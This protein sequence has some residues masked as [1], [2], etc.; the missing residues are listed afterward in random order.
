MAAPIW[1]ASP[2]EVHSAL[3]SNGPGPGSLVA[4]ATA[5][6][7][8]S[9]EYAST[10]AEL[11]GLLGAVPGWAWQGPS[12]EWYVAAH[13]PYVAWLTQASADAA[14]AAAQHEAAAAAYTTA[15]AAMPTLAELAANHVIHTVLVATNFFGINTIPITLNEA[16]YVRM[17]LQAAAVM[18]LYQAAS[19]AALASAPRT[20]P[21][22][23]VMNPGGGAASTVGA[24]NPWQWLLALLQQLWNAYTGFY[25]WMLQLIWQF[26]QD[27]IGNSIKIIIAFLTNPIQALITYGPL[28]FALGYQIFF[29]LVG[30]PTWGMI[31]SSPFLLPAGLGLGLAAIAFLPIVLAP[32]VIPPASTPLAAA[33]VAAGSVWPAVS[34]AVTGAG[35]AWGCDARGGRGR[36]PA[37]SVPAEP[38]AS[39]R[40]CLATAGLAGAVPP[41]ASAPVAMAETR[42]W[43]ATA[44]TVGQ[45]PVGLL[46]V[47]VARAGCYSAKMG[48]PG[49]E[50]PNPGQPP[51]GNLHINWPGRQQTA[52]IYEIGSRSVGGA[53]KSGCK[54]WLGSVGWRRA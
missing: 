31:L 16:D 1:M 51:M 25:G 14:G 34:M 11:S 18:G 12:A 13:L 48:C 26:L 40:F 19:G 20:V 46:A 53:G 24:V 3:L 17:W 27:P 21:A 9:A 6:S 42:C 7:Q 28:L 36:A 29:N 54:S 22:P 47:P 4:A 15:L 49:R 33:A 10:A 45:V 8:L 38:A 32:A 43:S 52:H 50:R 23:T 35:T 37:A 5:W 2:P 39:A 41:V 44:A 30:W